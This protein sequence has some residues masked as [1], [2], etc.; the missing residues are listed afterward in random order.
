MLIYE[1]NLEVNSAIF[2]NY[3]LWLKPHIGELLALKGFVKAE[4]LLEQQAGEVAVKKVTV[5]YYLDNYED[6]LNYID[7]HAP[8]MR[9]D[10]LERFNGQFRVHSRR[11]LH[12]EGSYL[13]QT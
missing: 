10:A 8:H 6:Y 4:L 3:M 9:K 12:V 2:D 1:V 7:N 13:A 11:V 5:A